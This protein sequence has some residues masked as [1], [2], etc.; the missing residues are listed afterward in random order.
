MPN[1]STARTSDPGGRQHPY[2]DAHATGVKSGSQRI[3]YKHMKFS[4]FNSFVL[5]QSSFLRK[6]PL[7]RE[8]SG[9]NFREW[10]QHRYQTSTPKHELLKKHHIITYK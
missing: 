10:Q 8:Q 4:A 9:L 5:Q 3:Q 6:D 7:K 1:N 2:Q